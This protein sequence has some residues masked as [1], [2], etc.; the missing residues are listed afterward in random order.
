[1]IGHFSWYEMVWRSLRGDSLPPID[2]QL[3]SHKHF[4]HLC[5]ATIAALPGTRAHCVADG[6]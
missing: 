4:D 5:D 1:V 6:P 3:I 2:A